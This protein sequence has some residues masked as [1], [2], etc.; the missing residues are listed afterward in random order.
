[1]HK[2]PHSTF[3]ERPT[4]LEAR[5]LKCPCDQTFNYELDRDQDMKIWMHKKLCDNWSLEYPGWQPRKTVT[6]KQ[7]EHMNVN[8]RDFC[9]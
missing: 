8:R 4:Y 1:M 7:Y 5:V 2:M 3:K 6:Q 9:R